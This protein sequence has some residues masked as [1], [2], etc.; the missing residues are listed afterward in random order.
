MDQYIGENSKT[1][2]L[3][4]LESTNDLTEEYTLESGG[5]TRCMGM[6]S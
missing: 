5:K 3:K 6:E 4:A 1:M 2:T